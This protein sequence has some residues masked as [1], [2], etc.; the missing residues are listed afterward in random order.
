MSFLP[1]ATVL[2]ADIAPNLQRACGNDPDWVCEHFYDWT[3]SRFWSSVVDWTIAKPLTIVVIVLVAAIAARIVR[4]LVSRSMNRMF[5]SD[6]RERGRV[7]R[8][9]R[10]RTSAVLL[11]TGDSSV[12]AQGR[13]ETLT[14]VFRSMGTALVW[15][16]AAFFV[17]EAVGISLGPLLATAGIAGIALGFGTQT[18][19]RD[20]ITGFFIVAEDQ[21]GVG[22]VIDLGGGAKGTVERVT[23]RA[24]H[25][26]DTEGTMWHVANG[27]ITKVANKSQEWARALIDVV[28]PYSA[29][30]DAV[31][32][33]MQNVADEIQADPT[34]SPEILERAEIWGI[35]E[36]DQDGVHVRL[37]I[38]TRPASQFGVLRELRG[39]LKIAFDNAGISFAYGGSP[40]EVVLIDARKDRGDPTDTIATDTEPAV[41]A[42]PNPPASGVVGFGPEGDHDAGFG[43][44]ADGD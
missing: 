12:R 15:F 18:M 2:A 7:G 34:W 37:V 10:E 19:V 22:D 39:R 42:T 26:R 6:E 43:G 27:Q 21:F 35:Q 17:L 23:L 33:V 9:V 5:A 30:I 20:F 24:T 32:G 14:A 29:D 13:L 3:G 4:W 11:S 25:L 41:T 36:F 28:L 38:K 44:D 31:S 8:K 1:S 16:V 40:T